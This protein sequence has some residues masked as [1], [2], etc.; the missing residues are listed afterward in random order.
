MAE[1]DVRLTKIGNAKLALVKAVKESCGLGLKEAKYLVD[2]CPS[3]LKEGL[4]KY[5]AEFIQMKIEET[6]SSIMLI[7]HGSEANKDE[8]SSIN[9]FN[10]SIK[11]VSYGVA[12]LQVIKAVMGAC[13]LGLQDAKDLVEACP[14][15]LKDSLAK[16]TAEHILIEIEGAGATAILISNGSDNCDALAEGQELDINE[17]FGSMIYHC[18]LDGKDFGPISL[19]QFANMARY[20]LANGNTL[21]WKNGMANWAIAS[22]VADFQGIV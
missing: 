7:Q 5:E 6:G 21:V 2:A 15:I 17:V 3:T 22:S 4:T 20:G 8:Q 19:R 13:G 1:Y 18:V 9:G 12:K 16:E 11:L 10:Y 14:C